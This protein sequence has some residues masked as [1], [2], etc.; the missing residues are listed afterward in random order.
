MNYSFTRLTLLLILFFFATIFTVNHAAAQTTVTITGA[1]VATNAPFDIADAKYVASG[2]I[3]TAQEINA[4]GTITTLEW[5]NFSCPVI[6]IP[7]VKIYMKL[8]PT[9]TTAWST[10]NYGTTATS[11]TALYG[12]TLVYSGSYTS[13]ANNWADPK[14]LQTPFVYSTGYNLEVITE[15]DYG[16]ED[17]N[18][19]SWYYNTNLSSGDCS[20]LSSSQS[21]LS[22]TS[23]ST[24][25]IDEYRPAIRITLTANCAVPTISGFSPSDACA[26]SGATISVTGTGFVSGATTATINGTTAAVSF[27]DT[28]HITITLPAGASGTGPIAVTTCGGTINSASNFTVDAAPSFVLNPSASAQYVCINGTATQFL[29]T[30]NGYGTLTYQW[31]QNTT[32]S[33]SGGTQITGAT[34]S[35]YTP[36]TNTAGTLYYYCIVSGGCTPAATSAVSGVVNVAAGTVSAGP[37]IG[38]TTVCSGSTDTFSLAAVAGAT[39]YTW[40]LPG[41]WTGSS[42]TNT[43]Y[44]TA[45]STGGTISVTANNACGSSTPEMSIITLNTVPATPGAITGNT[46]ICSGITDTFSIAPVTGATSYHWTFPSGWSGT[47]GTPTVNAIA[48]SSG[49]TVSVTANNACGASSAQTLNVSLASGPAQPGAIASTGSSCNGAVDTFTIAAVSGAIS[50]TWSLP[51]GWTGSSTTDTIIATAGASGG[52]VS[53]TANN[54]CGSSTAQTLSVSSGSAPATPGTITGPVSACN[55]DALT[56][57]ISAVSGATSYTWTLPNGWTGS[58]T[59][60]S[61]QVTAAGSGGTIT[62]IANNSCGS[63]SAQSLVIA[64][65]STPATPG[66][67]SSTGNP[68]GG[69]DTFSVAPVSGATSYTWT[70]PGGWTGTSTT[71]TIIS[72][73][74]SSG[75]TVSVTANNGCGSSQPQAITVSGGASPAMPGAITGPTSVCSGDQDT[76]SVAPVSGATSYAWSLP[77]GW[78]GT[79]TTDTIDAIAAGAGTISV[80]AINGCGSSTAQTLSISA[81]SVPS[82]PGSISGTS[83]VCSGQLDT[84]SIAPVNGATSYTWNLPTGWTGTSTTNSIVATAG[85]GAGLVQVAANN[86]CGSSSAQ[87]MIVTIGSGPSEPGAITGPAVVCGGNTNI[88]S[89]APVN[90]AT[91]YTWTLPNGWT[92]TSVT[93]S[94]SATAAGA[95][96][97]SVTANNG[98]GSSTAQTLTVTTG[99][100]PGMPGAISGPDSICAGSMGTYS[101]DTVNGA[102]SYTWTLPN[103]WSG[104]STTNSINATGGTGGGTVSVTA[105]NGC[106]QSSAQTKTV[107]LNPN[108]TVALNL[109]N[110][111]VCNNMNP[112][113]A[114]SGGSPPGGTFSGQGVS[115]TNLDASSLVAGNYVVTY[116]YTSPLGCSASDTETVVVTVC[117]GIENAANAGIQV[118]PNPFSDAVV[119]DLGGNYGNGKVVLMDATGRTISETTFGAGLQNLQLNTGLL[120]GG[121][122]LLNIIENGKS[123]AVRKLFKME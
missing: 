7:S 87:T 9:T 75:G 89:V 21:G 50:Y 116:S 15:A 79:S 76:F 45:G 59:S 64:A 120:P 29:V 102:S 37:I 46:S 4:S 25:G 6:T 104:S 113:L 86:G 44:V 8:V 93:D 65:G 119:I 61:I 1:G 2:E 111:Q 54:G 66:S 73:A 67:I 69:A 85:S 11:G 96:I 31:Y 34:A 42:T 95:G 22:S 121:A 98:C 115:G 17:D 117:S 27:V 18:E 47:N 14:T 105:S 101:V 20:W 77:N 12:A 33:N 58:S 55:G 39:S 40:T 112:V 24:G 56:Y 60:T 94:I 62:V 49:G 83:P 26:G 78:T 84:F 74:G 41:G 82:T 72:V 103:G 97:I 90:G 70:L 51:G 23:N 122:Y 100:T 35:T 30:A 107:S 118:Y 92:G 106:G 43:I 71:N 57:S 110:N 16:S 53:V 91:S 52:T 32:G 10:M 5:D 63:S 68:C 108:P 114:L 19:P 99:A 38:P 88:Y 36:L 48:G 81:G 123:I 109:P 3:Y 80:V 13:D 28:D